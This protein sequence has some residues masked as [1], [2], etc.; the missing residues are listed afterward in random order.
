MNWYKTRI[1][2]TISWLQVLTA[3]ASMGYVNKAM[4]VFGNSVVMSKKYT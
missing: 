3:V 1:T 2:H 4:M